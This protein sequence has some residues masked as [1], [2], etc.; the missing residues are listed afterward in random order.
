MGINTRAKTKSVNDTKT[1][2]ELEWLKLENESLVKQ[3]ELISEDYDKMKK[4]LV[5][6]EKAMSKQATKENAYFRLRKVEKRPTVVL[7]DIDLP[8]PGDM[9]TE[10]DCDLER[11]TTNLVI[12]SLFKPELASYAEQSDISHTENI[13]VHNEED[14]CEITTPIQKEIP[15]IGPVQTAKPK[16]I[17][18]GTSLVKDLLLRS[19]GLDGC[20]YCYPGQTVPYI[21]SRVPHILEGQ[22]PEYIFIQCGGNDIEH[23]SNHLVIKP[24]STVLLG[25]VP[26][27]GTDEHLHTRIHMFNTYLFNRGKI[28]S[29]I[30]YVE[31][32]PTDIRHYKYDLVHFNKAGAA[33]FQQNI[34][35][36][37]NYLCSFPALPLI[38]IT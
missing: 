38:R 6:L 19:G 32:A 16:V 28:Q 26:L 20:T 10:D 27:R 11:C 2:T 31:P 12:E 21:R 7:N 33:I 18:I 35:N 1:Y 34:V 15:V 37:I 25:A 23:N 5:D 4:R 3:M 22:D 30:I 24:H 14:T 36:K 9:I 29:D 13:Y 8:V 17:A